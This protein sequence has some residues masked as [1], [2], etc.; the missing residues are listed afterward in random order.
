MRI[1]MA[2]VST[3][4]ITAPLFGQGSVSFS[5]NIGT[6]PAWGP[7]GYDY[8]EYYYLPDIEVY[9]YVPQRRFFYFE[10][11]RWVN[12]LSLPRRYHQF[13]LYSSY[14][15]VLNERTPYRNHGVYRG[16]YSTF[17]GRRNQPFIR[18][19]RDEKYFI[20]EHHPDHRQWQ[21]KRSKNRP[22]KADKQPRNRNR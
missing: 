2:I 13:D 6:Q 9:Y 8:V 11:G 5:F 14:K 1:I 16:R 3:L 12:G 15:V 21:E 17:R 18:D 22:D 4:F 10:G 19:S 7:T 20:N